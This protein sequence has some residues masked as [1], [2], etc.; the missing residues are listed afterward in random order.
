MGSPWW[1]QSTGGLHW[2]LGVCTAG[3][4]RGLPSHNPTHPDPRPLPRDA[5]RVPAGLPAF[6][7]QLG[8]C[9]APIQCHLLPL[10]GSVPSLPRFPHMPAGLPAFT[11]SWWLPL[12]N[13][14]KQMMLAVLICFIDI[15]ESISIAKALAQVRH[16]A[17]AAHGQALCSLLARGR[18]A[19]GGVVAPRAGLMVLFSRGVVCRVGNRCSSSACVRAS[20]LT[21]WRAWMVQAGVPPK[22]LPH[23]RSMH[24]IPALPLY[25][26]PCRKR[27][28]P[29]C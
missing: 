9:P 16:S 15:C 12:Y 25:L 26:G 14:G 18:G 6:H 3:A 5:A 11:V 1:L 24:S 23:E 19:G 8:G 28:A 4:M 13:V 10:T 22:L 27:Q 20:Y 2:L 21:G 29:T 7:P 17:G